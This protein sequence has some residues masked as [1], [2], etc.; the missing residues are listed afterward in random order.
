MAFAPVPQGH[1]NI[2]RGRAAQS[3]P[4]SGYV[5]A[6]DSQ[7]HSAET[8]HAFSLGGL[9]NWLTKKKDEITG[10]SLVSGTTSQR[11]SG[12]D[13][14]SMH[15]SRRHSSTDILECVDQIEVDVTTFQVCSNS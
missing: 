12:R 4:S 6:T 15:T 11:S 8:K 14:Q 3:S 9:K 1:N 13:D 2:N 5:Q 10:G 7:T